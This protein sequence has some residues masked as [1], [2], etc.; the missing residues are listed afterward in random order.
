VSLHLFPWK[1]FLAVDETRK[2]PRINFA[3]AG[4]YPSLIGAAVAFYFRPTN[5]LIWVAISAG[6]VWCT[7]SFAKSLILVQRAAI[8]G[9]S[10]V[11]AFASADRLYYGEWACPP[12]RFLYINV[13]QSL[14]VFYGSN[15]VDYYFTEGLPL[16]LT[17]ALPFAAYGTWQ[18]L[19][20]GNS[21]VNSTSVWQSKVKFIFALAT[22]FTVLALST[23]DH[24][25]MRFLYPLLPILHILAAKPL[26]TFF[27]ALTRRKSRAVILLVL[28]AANVL[29]A[30]YTAMIHQRGVIDVMHYLRQTQESRPE[31][32]SVDGSTISSATNMTVGFLMPC[33]ST[34]WRIY[35]VYPEIEAW[36][37]TCEPPL[38]MTPAQRAAYMDEADIFY[39]DPK[40][41]LQKN[42]QD[43]STARPNSE[44]A[45]DDQTHRRQWP[46]YLV[47]FEHLEAT[48]LPLLKERDYAE[49]KRFFNTHWH[50]DGRRKGDAIVLAR[51]H[52]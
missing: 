1:W 51:N 11:A 37:L 33:H 32:Y 36:A 49:T 5:I 20:R 10:V 22:A 31:H 30:Y 3:P 15:R 39:A 18:S 16:L 46:E 12:L 21:D 4:L 17:T 28:L 52:T 7:R 50:D 23:I 47:I 48:L 42:M 35:L 2:Q 19:R 24:K 40:T 6:L 27:S 41:W 45:V 44:R 9:T 29:I 38:H 13:V 43:L 34:P 25:E 14:A 8:V 26:A